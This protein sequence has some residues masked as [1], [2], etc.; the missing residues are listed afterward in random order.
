V[1][2]LED[3]YPLL[4]NL[5]RLHPEGHRVAGGEGGAFVS[6]E[7]YRGGAVTHGADLW[8]LGVLAYFMCTGTIPN[9]A[10]F[11]ENQFRPIGVSLELS[12]LVNRLM[13]FNPAE[14]IGFR[15]IGELQSHPFFRDF[16]WG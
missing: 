10:N 12:D 3:G 4:T 16:N 11:V 13:V 2:I 1:V 9:A 8:S 15:Y 5:S 14:R 6:P 7:E